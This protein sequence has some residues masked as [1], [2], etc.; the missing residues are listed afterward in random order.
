MNREVHVRFWE[1]VGVKL[2]RATQLSCSLGTTAGFHCRVKPKLF[3]HD[4][5]PISATERR[6][7]CALDAGHLTPQR[8][9]VRLWLF[10]YRV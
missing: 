8:A 9:S 1:G 7:R 10:T 2:S 4:N 6:R 3:G 5:H